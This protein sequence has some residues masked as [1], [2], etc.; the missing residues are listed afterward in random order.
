MRGRVEKLAVGVASHNQPRATGEMGLSRLSFPKVE[1]NRAA[2]RHVGTTRQQRRL[3][4]GVAGRAFDDIGPTQSTEDV[5]H[6]SPFH[7]R[8]T[9]RANQVDDLRPAVSES[10]D[11]R[12]DDGAPEAVETSERSGSGGE[13]QDP[14]L[15]RLRQCDTPIDAAIRLLNWA[16]VGRETN[17]KPV[18]YT[19]DGAGVT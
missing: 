2:P 13:D 15:S 3:Q 14:D 6:Q 5:R 7:G 16:W 11:E 17:L 19:C 18:H 8:V 12:T 4:S 1:S 9:G 10:P